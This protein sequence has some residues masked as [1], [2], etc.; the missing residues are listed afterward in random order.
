MLTGE[1]ADYCLRAKIDMKELNGCMRDPVLYRVNM[2][3]HHRTGTKFK[4]YPTYD[5]VCPIIDSLEG[6]TH[7]MRTNE[8]SDRIDQYNWMINALKLRPVEIY[9]FSRLNLVN[10][11]L[12]KRKLQEF[13]NEKI[14]D[15]W[16][17]PRFPTLRVY[18]L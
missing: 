11:C 8:Y 14:V 18:I 4:A 15:G 6:V 7:A 16:D 1:K 13:V 9:E 5:F 17:D 12:S 10:T 3:P 2:T